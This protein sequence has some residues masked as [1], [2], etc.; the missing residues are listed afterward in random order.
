MTTDE[1]LYTFLG[2]APLTI[3]VASYSMCSGFML[4]SRHASRMIRRL[5][6]L[7]TPKEAS[8]W[9]ESK[10]RAC[11]TGTSVSPRGHHTGVLYRPVVPV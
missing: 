2:L 1:Y 7:Q 9:I 6:G 8:P 10:A 4:L 11:K 3:S 5:F